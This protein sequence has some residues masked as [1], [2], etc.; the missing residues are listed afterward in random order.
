MNKTSLLQNLELFQ[1]QQNVAQNQLLMEF[2]NN[3]INLKTTQLLAMNQQKLLY[4][5][6]CTSNNFSNFFFLIV[7]LKIFELKTVNDFLG[8]IIKY[9]K[10]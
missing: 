6:F 8:F 7:F 3:Q 10:F 1:N 4:K 5:Q 9:L 2:L